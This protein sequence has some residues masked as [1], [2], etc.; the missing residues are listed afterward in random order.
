[1][2]SAA[3]RIVAPV[4]LLA[5]IVVGCY[6]GGDGARVST[7]AAALSGSSVVGSSGDKNSK[8]AVLVSL[9]QN[10]DTYTVRYSITVTGLS[11]PDQPYLATI[12]RGG[13][14]ANGGPIVSF[15]NGW[16]NTT[17]AGASSYSYTLRGAWY[18]AQGIPTAGKMLSDVL[19]SIAQKPFNY[20]TQVYT[21]SYG[22][23]AR[24]TA[25][26]GGSSV[27]SSGAAR[28]QMHVTKI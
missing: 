28:G 10:G 26:N 18:N 9:F 21:S 24:Y 15:P 17:Q 8:G 22:G 5:C 20:Y 25:G 23:K 14:Y 16:V 7:L 1:M 19:K 12:N 27:P 4:V 3:L 13:R 11:K 6:A 2:A